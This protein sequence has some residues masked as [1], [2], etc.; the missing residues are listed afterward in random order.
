MNVDRPLPI[1]NHQL[2]ISG[3]SISETPEVIHIRSASPL[4]VLSSAI[5]GSGFRRVRHILNAHV[6][7][8][9]NSTNPKADLRVLARRCGVDGQFVGLLTAVYLRKAR[10]AFFEEDGLSVGALITAGVGNAASAGITQPYRPQAGTIN[11]ILLLNANLTRGA[12]LNAFITATEAKT[13]VIQSRNI[14]TPDGDLATGTSTDTITVAATGKGK[15][16]N[17][18]GSVTV[19][20]WLIAR[21]VR[22]ALGESLDAT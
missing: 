5:V 12:M 9:Y 7:K 8:D 18:A 20:G 1:T 2:P 14:H 22:Q 15:P 4:T 16:Q 10:L 11:I 17:Y 13:A 3:I 6:D 21:A 19:L